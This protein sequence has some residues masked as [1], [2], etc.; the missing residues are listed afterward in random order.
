MPVVVLKRMIPSCAD[1]L[2][3]VVPVGTTTPVV[4]L[5]SNKPVPCVVKVMSALVTMLP[6]LFAVNSVLPVVVDRFCKPFV[7]V[8]HAPDM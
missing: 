1:G 5:K 6:M 4:V 7:P 2:W 3:A 8:Y